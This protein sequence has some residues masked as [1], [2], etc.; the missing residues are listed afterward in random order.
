MKEFYGKVAVAGYQQARSKEI[1]AIVSKMLD[2]DDDDDT[3][4][5]EGQVWLYHDASA[6]DLVRCLTHDVWRANGGYCDV[7]VTISEPIEY[8]STKR[9]YVQFLADGAE[10][11]KQ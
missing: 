9:D 6:E 8:R 5:A 10:T 2:C 3:I 7:V 1:C 11:S 4:E